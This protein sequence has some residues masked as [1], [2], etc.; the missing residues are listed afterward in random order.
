MRLYAYPGDEAQADAVAAA[1]GVKRGRIT[2]HRF[3]DGET[4]ARV[5]D[6]PASECWIVCTLADPDPKVLPLLLAAT[7]LRDQGA[8]RVGLLSPYLAY[9]RQDKRFHPGEPVSARI[10]GAL[11][12][13]YFDALVTVDPHLHRLQGL[14]EVFP[15]ASACLHATSLL[16]DW[17]RANV[18]QPLL[19][20]P[21]G[22]S[23]QWVSEVATQVDAPWICMSK[24]RAGDR[25]VRV[26]LPEGLPAPDRRPVLVD[27][28]ISS[29]HTLAGAARLLR[30]AGFAAP[31]C[32]AVHGLFAPGAREALREAGIAPVAVT[33]SVPQPESVMPLARLLAD[34]LR[35][36]GG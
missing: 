9:L 21:D 12:G 34:G 6:E 30:A 5:E 19:V 14:H 31:A 2:W 23:A 8:R 15:H 3:P 26:E 10:F 25:D 24:R 18:A 20:G 1:L 27:D 7:A 36:L 11:L 29:G 28:I 13:R 33:D 22:E 32:A 4:L 17:I 35:R 16:A